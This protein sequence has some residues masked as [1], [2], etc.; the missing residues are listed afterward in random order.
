MVSLSAPFLISRTSSPCH[1]DTRSEQLL[2]MYSYSL[3]VLFLLVV[4]V[5]ILA[6]F[7]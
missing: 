5:A 1:H 4:L 7:L 3:F 2:G 6:L